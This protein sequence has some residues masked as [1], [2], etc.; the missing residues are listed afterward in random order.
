MRL[1]PQQGNK[2]EPAVLHGFEGAIGISF[3]GSHNLVVVIIHRDNEDT[4]RLQLIF[5]GFGDIGGAGSHDY[6][7]E[8]SKSGQ[9]FVAVAEECFDQVTGSR[10]HLF[11]F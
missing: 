11:C 5:Q 8:G 3:N 2:P 10:K 6:S 9:A 4:A 1:I 7:I